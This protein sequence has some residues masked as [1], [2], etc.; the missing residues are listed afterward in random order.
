MLLFWFFHVKKIQGKS[1]QRFM[2]IYSLNRYTSRDITFQYMPNSLKTF[3]LLF[4]VTRKRSPY[5]YV[6]CRSRVLS[7]KKKYTGSFF[8]HCLLTIIR[9]NKDSIVWCLINWKCTIIIYLS[10]LLFHYYFP[11]RFTSYQSL[12]KNKKFS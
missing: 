8:V 2:R 10:R 9:N 3:L 1:T 4:L 5:F 11:Y 7:V 12:N 6:T